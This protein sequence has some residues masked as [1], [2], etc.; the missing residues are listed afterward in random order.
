MG[1]VSLDVGLLGPRTTGQSL[2]EVAH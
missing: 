1:I 2:E